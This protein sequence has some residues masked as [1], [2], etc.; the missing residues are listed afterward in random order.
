MRKIRFPPCLQRRKSQVDE[1]KVSKQ[2]N[3]TDSGYGILSMD[4]CFDVPSV[5]NGIGTLVVTCLVQNTVVWSERQTM[6]I[7]PPH[8]I[9]SFNDTAHQTTDTKKR[10]ISAVY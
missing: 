6:Y 10:R 1:A 3:A 9:V 2:T 8:P 4:K 7:M 5:A